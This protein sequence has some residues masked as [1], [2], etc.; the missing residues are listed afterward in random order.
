MNKLVCMLRVKDG[1]LFVDKWLENMHKLVDEIVVVDNGSTDGTLEK[2]QGSP[3]VVSIDHTQGFDEGR[4]KIMAYKRALE[5]NPDWILWVD[6]DEIFEDRMTRKRLEKMMS[7]KTIT[8]YWFRRFHLHNDENH[9]EASFEKIFQIAW[10]DRVLWKNQPSGYFKYEKIHCALIRGI[11]GRNKIT[12]YRIR[13]F[14]QINKDYLKRK[15]EV[16]L[17]VDPVQRDMYVKHR[18]QQL[19]T[20]EWFEFKDNPFLVGFENLLLNTILMFRVISQKLN[21]R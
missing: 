20:W 8:K 15:T 11:T 13:H 9:F 19:N 6:I 3:K 17:R 16:Y 2:L 7:S 18:D 4:D 12:N 14:G 1:I 10:P 21:L 5:R